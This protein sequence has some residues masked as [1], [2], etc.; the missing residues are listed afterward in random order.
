MKLGW[1]NMSFLDTYEMYP[2]WNWDWRDWTIPSP[3][4]NYSVVTPVKNQ[5][6]CNS[7]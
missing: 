3:E 6:T 7:W 4:G 5:T 1:C 2:P